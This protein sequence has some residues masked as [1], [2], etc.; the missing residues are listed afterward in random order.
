MY[1]SDG[2]GQHYSCS[3]GATTFSPF[4]WGSSWKKK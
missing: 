3:V 4:S 1:K 2:T